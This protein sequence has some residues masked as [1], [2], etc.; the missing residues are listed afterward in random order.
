MATSSLRMPSGKT[1][2]VSHGDTSPAITARVLNNR[3]PSQP[4]TQIVSSVGSRRHHRRPVSVTRMRRSVHST[5]GIL[6]EVGLRPRGR[7]GPA[8]AG[9]VGANAVQSVSAGSTGARRTSA[10]RPSYVRSAPPVRALRALV[11]PLCTSDVRSATPAR[12]STS[13][14]FRTPTRTSGPPARRSPYVH[15]QDAP[16]ARSSDRQTGNPIQM[17]PALDRLRDSCSLNRGSRNSRAT[18]RRRPG[19][20][21]W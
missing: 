13:A 7:G 17:L 1:I 15:P 10:P 14:F 12:H 20:G 9:H 21:T 3:R 19:R 11:A 4:S 18:V 16:N 5:Q 8:Q 6:G 2:I